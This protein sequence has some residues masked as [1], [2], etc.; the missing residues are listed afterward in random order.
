M[1]GVEARRIV[2][3]G[4]H[5]WVRQGNG[6]EVPGLLVHWERR[7]G[8]WWGRVAMIDADGDPALADVLSSHLRPADSAARTD[9]AAAE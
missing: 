4:Q 2:P 3:K 7:N 6:D 8:T 1:T 5:V 9:G